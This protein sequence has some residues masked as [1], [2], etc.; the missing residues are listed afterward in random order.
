[1]TL[2]GSHPSARV[3]VHHFICSQVSFVIVLSCHNAHS[4]H[5]LPC[6][7]SHSEW[8]QQLPP[9]LQTFLVCFPCSFCLVTQGGSIAHH[10]IGVV[11][12]VGPLLAFGHPLDLQLVIGNLSHSL[13][14]G[15]HRRV[16]PG[17]RHW[18]RPQHRHR[19]HWPPYSCRTN[20]LS[21]R[22]RLA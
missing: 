11:H 7:F 22:T 19:L 1:M 6:N 8:C 20:L 18:Y 16:S 12:V 17:H 5:I 21:S 4:Q 15:Q 3:D 13:M 2:D 14:T 9:Q 10:A